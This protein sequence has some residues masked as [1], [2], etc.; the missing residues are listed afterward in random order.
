MYEPAFKLWKMNRQ[1]RLQAINEM[2]PKL[3]EQTFTYLLSQFNVNCDLY[4]LYER[5]I[6]DMKQ[7]RERVKEYCPGE[8]YVNT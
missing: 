8:I 2:E 3:R 4:D 7:L 5:T 6:Y 1:E